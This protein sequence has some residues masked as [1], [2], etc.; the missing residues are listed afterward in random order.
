MAKTPRYTLTTTRGEVAIPSVTEIIG[1]VV[2]RKWNASPEDMNRG[3]M[4]HKAIALDL[5]GVLDESS[6]SHDA[7]L[8]GKVLQARVFM[9]QHGYDRHMVNKSEF[10]MVHTGLRFG[11]TPD[12]L[13]LDGTLLDWKS[14][15]TPT[16]EIQLGGYSVLF[17]EAL[18]I[19]VKQIMEVVLWQDG[20]SV[21]VFESVSRAEALFMATYSVAGWMRK[22]N[23]GVGDE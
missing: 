19:K 13:M 6:I 8:W 9:A 18:G 3:S 16:T 1:Q 17:R 20:H 11:G 10:R 12:V 22:N 15:H 5:A 4:M 14:S 2:P 23:M 21:T 7:D